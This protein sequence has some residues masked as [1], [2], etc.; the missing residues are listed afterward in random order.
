MAQQIALR[1]WCDRA[2]GTACVGFHPTCHLQLHEQMGY[3]ASAWTPR[4]TDWRTAPS[5]DSGRPAAVPEPLAALLIELP[6]REIGGQ[7]PEWEELEAQIGWARERQHSPCIWTERVSGR[8]LRIMSETHAEI[9]A[10]FDSVYVSFYK[11]IGAIT[12]A[13]LAGTTDFIAEARVWQ[14]RHGGR[15]LSL[16]PYVLS[17]RAGLRLR[18]SRFPQYHHGR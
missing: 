11:G 7:L 13:A 1:I 3:R 14:V 5:P 16:F 2:H 8:P 6:Q 9:A 10:L 15:L 17:A 18:M 4:A 12:G